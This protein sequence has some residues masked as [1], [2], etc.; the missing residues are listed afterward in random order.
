MLL[1]RM[2][3]AGADPLSALVLL[4]MACDSDPIE[5]ELVEIERLLP[6]TYTYPGDVPLLDMEIN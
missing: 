5:Q 1:N 2:R 3:E 4:C 6:D